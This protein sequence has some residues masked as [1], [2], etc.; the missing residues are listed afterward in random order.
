MQPQLST[1]LFCSKFALTSTLLPQS[2]RQFHIT[3]LLLRFSIGSNAIRRPYLPPAFTLEFRHAH[4]QLVANPEFNSFVGFTQN[5]PQSHWQ[6]HKTEWLRGS[7]SPEFP[8]IISRPK[9]CPVDPYLVPCSYSRSSFWCRH[10]VHLSSHRFHFRSRTY[11]AIPALLFHSSNLP[12]LQV[13]R[14]GGLS[15]CFLFF[16]VS[17]PP[18]TTSTT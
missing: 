12:T 3:A 10:S 7:F 11:T 17:L 4:P 16:S 2:H 9:R 8:R 15:G 18:D 6:F 1:C 5:F 13:V 14:N